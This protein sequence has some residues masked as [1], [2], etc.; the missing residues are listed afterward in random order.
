MSN[1]LSELQSLPIWA[2]SGWNKLHQ[3][4]IKAEMSLLS[5]QSCWKTLFCTE[6]SWRWEQ[7][8]PRYFIPIKIFVFY[9]YKN[10]LYFY[11]YCIFVYLYTFCKYKF[12]YKIII[13]NY[14]HINI[15]I[16]YLFLKFWWWRVRAAI[17]YSGG[18]FCADLFIFSRDWAWKG[19]EMRI[20]DSGER[21]IPSRVGRDS[22]S[23]FLFYLFLIFFG[24]LSS[25]QTEIPRFVLKDLC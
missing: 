16:F 23:W 15:Y 25:L 6:S 10:N 3:E 1:S 11:I 8:L 14:I 13:Y 18:V 21:R 17:H 9:F 5:Q 19:G 22:G 20:R 4:L 2:R 24:M 7:L 12:I